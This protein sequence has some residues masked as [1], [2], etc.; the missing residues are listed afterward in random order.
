MQPSS[1]KFKERKVSPK[2]Y[3]FQT[4]DNLGY[5]TA[6]VIFQ[7]NF[8]KIHEMSSNL[9]KCETSKNEKIEQW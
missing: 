9:V 3:E 5:S 8:E 7:Q 2:R 1:L 4:V 6:L